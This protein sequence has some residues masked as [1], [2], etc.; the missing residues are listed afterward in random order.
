MGE[1][2]RR[3]TFEERKANAVKKVVPKTV[4]VQKARQHKASNINL[5]ALLSSLGIAHYFGVK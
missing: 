4:I 3:G 2:K 1:A 5:I